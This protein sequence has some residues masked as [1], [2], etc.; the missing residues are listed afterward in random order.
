NQQWKQPNRPTTPPALARVVAKPPYVGCNKPTCPNG[1]PQPSDSPPSQLSPPSRS[2]E[3]SGAPNH[4]PW[5]PPRE[6]PICPPRR[7]CTSV[8]APP[9]RPHAEGRAKTSTSRRCPPTP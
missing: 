5:T 6:P 8:P 4:R 2:P 1:Q 7:S 9:S 3:A